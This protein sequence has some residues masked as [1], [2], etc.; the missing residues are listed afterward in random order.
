MTAYADVA[1]MGL[2]AMGSAALYQLSRIPGLRVVG[3]D[4]F[5]PPHSN[6]SSHGD[7]RATRSAP[8][9]GE[10]LVPLVRRSIELYSGEIATETGRTLFN[11]TGGLII[12]KHGQAGY[13]NVDDPFASTVAAAQ[14]YGVEYTLLNAAEASELYPTIHLEEDEQAY[15]EPSGG[16]LSA[17]DCVRSHLELAKRNGAELR[18]NE[19]MIKYKDTGSG[20]TVETNKGVYEVGTLIVAAGPWLKGILPE[21]A[22]LFELQRLVLYWFEV[23]NDEAFSAYERMPRVGWA[24]GSGTYAFPAIDGRSGGI[25]VASEEFSVID[26][27]EAIDRTVSRNE[28]DDMFESNVR[29]RLLGLTGRAVRTATC[30][31]TMTP[32]S[33][34]LIDRLPEHQNVI[35]ASPCSGHGFKYSAAI[36]EALAELAT[37][38][39]TTLDIA[40]FGFGRW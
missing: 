6:G 38:G 14:R 23:G 39:K 29:G 37:A 5:S 40:P 10:E 34:F 25:K 35:V 17:E 27:P 31:Y 28:I 7:T 15:Y 30:M 18:L 11:R 1:V 26:S 13:H 16:V 2:G 33:R 32:D 21:Y 12:G 8:F 4:A 22:S 20:V 9:E 24:Y 3:F 19:R 36:G